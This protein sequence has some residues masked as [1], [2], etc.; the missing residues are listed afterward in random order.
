MGWLR[1]LTGMRNGLRG[2]RSGGGMLLVMMALAGLLP[3]KPTKGTDS[4]RL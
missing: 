2:A 3:Q 1:L 4:K